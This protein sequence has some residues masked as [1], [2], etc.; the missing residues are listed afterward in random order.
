ME[1]FVHIL[2]THAF[3]VLPTCHRQHKYDRIHSS[4]DYMIIEKDFHIDSL[5]FQIP[6]S[7]SGYPSL[8]LTDSPALSKR[9]GKRSGAW[10]FYLIYPR[11]S[12]TRSGRRLS[13]P[14]SDDPGGWPVDL[15]SLSSWG[16]LF[17]SVRH[18]RYAAVAPNFLLLACA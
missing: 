11:A 6:G 5:Y 4:R 1:Q 12:C 18:R 9:P 14:G 15:A 16:M 17:S 2:F 10:H 13:V 7:Y 8:L 3:V